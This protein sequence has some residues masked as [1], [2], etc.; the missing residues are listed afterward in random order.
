M[1]KNMMMIMVLVCIALSLTGCW[2]YTEIEKLDFVLGAGVDQLEPDL[3]VVAEMVKNSGSGQE[4]EV[5]QLVMSTKGRSLSSS[6]RAL[7]NPAGRIVYWPHAQVYLISEEVAQDGILPAI[8]YVIRSRYVRTTVHLFVTKNCTVEEVFKSKP[9]FNDTVSEHLESVLQMQAIVAGFFPQQVWQFTSDLTSE[10]I[11]ATV[12]TIQL[13][14]NRGELAPIVEGT[15]VFKMDQMVGWLDGD[16]SQIFALLKGLYQNAYFVMDTRTSNG[17]FPITYETISN[18]VAVK[19]IVEGEK[20]S[21]S[22]E[23]NLKLNVVEIGA[24]G[25]DFKDEAQVRSIEEQISHTL[26]RRIKD[27]LSKIQVE[28]NSDVLGFGQL[29]RRKE[30]DIWRRHGDDWDDYLRDLSVDVTV[31][32]TIILTG[33]SS[34]PIVVRN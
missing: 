8:E 18:N 26:N 23:L 34:E 29:F 24:A 13:V 20:G 4:I 12:P 16:E 31:R 33:L 2:D 21:V 1:I 11:S 27:L 3:V 15:A 19:P 5:E 28:Y 14:H 30:P 25:I 6:A 22:I 17:V 10:G 9:P 7:S 32:C